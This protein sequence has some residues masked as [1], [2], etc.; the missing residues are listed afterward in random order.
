[1][2]VSSMPEILNTGRIKILWQDYD[3]LN[4]M[5]VVSMKSG[6]TQWFS[7]LELHVSGLAI[8]L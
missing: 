2:G 8:W 4:L 3:Y 1:M 7:V 6:L 5:L